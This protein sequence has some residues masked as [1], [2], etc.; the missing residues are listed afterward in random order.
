MCRLQ[1]ADVTDEK[2]RAQTVTCVGVRGTGTP[3]SWRHVPSLL[4]T[5]SIARSLPPFS[6]FQSVIFILKLDPMGKEVVKKQT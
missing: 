4:H 6:A 3:N 1:K 5:E 2:S